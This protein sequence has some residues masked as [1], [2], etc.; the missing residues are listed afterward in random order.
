MLKLN[1]CHRFSYFN[2]PLS[3]SRDIFSKGAV[4]GPSSEQNILTIPKIH[5]HSAV[6]LSPIRNV[7][8][9]TVEKSNP[10]L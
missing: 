10:L 4:S 6:S 9:E 5:Q 8:G 1:N 2:S 3:P 7:E